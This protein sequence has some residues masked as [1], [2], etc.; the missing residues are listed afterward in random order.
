MEPEISTIFEIRRT[1]PCISLDYNVSSG[2][3]EPLMPQR[4]S[5]PAIQRI[6]SSSSAPRQLFRHRRS[7]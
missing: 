4:D 5:I 6:I 7:F 3:L 2:A 1:I